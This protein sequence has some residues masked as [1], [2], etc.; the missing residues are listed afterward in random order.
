MSNTLSL[1]TSSFRS[2]SQ[3]FT[4]AGVTTGGPPTNHTWRRNGE[5]ITDG[6]PFNI[7][8]AVT[9]DTE[10]NR[11]DAG[12]TSTLVVTSR[13]PGVYE[14]IVSNRAMSIPLTDRFNIEGNNLFYCSFQRGVSNNAGSFPI[15]CQRNLVS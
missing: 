6:G 14:Y 15:Y 2:T 8:I 10:E 12:Y 11:I 1:L 4:L 9:S 13:F 5:V 7:S 3:N